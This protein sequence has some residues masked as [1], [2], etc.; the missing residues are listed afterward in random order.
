MTFTFAAL[1]ALE[2]SAMPA[3]ET[4]KLFEPRTFA[5]NTPSG[6]VEYQYRQLSPEKPVEGHKYPLVVFLHG[7]G[8]R[9]SEN[10]KQLAYLPEW[11]S[12]PEAREKY[13]CYLLA[14]QCPDGQ[15]WSDVDWSS[16][17]PLTLG[18]ASRPMKAVVGMIEEMMKSYPVDPKRV[19]L[20]GLSMGG[21][22]AWDL[23]ERMPDLFAAVAP[24]CGGGD[25]RAAH[26]LVK[27]PVWAWHGDADGAVPVERSRKM[28][29]AIKA[30]GGDPKYTELKDVGH[31]SW[32]RAYTD[33]DGVVPWMFQCVKRPDVPNQ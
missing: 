15:K 7:A 25:E 26:R 20:T 24:I 22:G 3:A 8:E 14:P 28:I 4:V 12:T 30:A 31:D 23:A 1:V 32:T 33:A 18:E 10:T 5:V 13:P 29:A 27:V 21:Y 11:L 19:Y 6:K 2:L 16:R 17:D 9:G